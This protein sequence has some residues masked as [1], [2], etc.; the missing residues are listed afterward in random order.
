MIIKVRFPITQ[1]I[2]GELGISINGI[3]E[4]AKGGFGLPRIIKIG[5]DR[6]ESREAEGERRKSAM[7]P[8]ETRQYICDASP[9]ASEVVRRWESPIAAS[10]EIGPEKMKDTKRMR[11]G[12]STK[13]RL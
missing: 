6:G 5:A 3:R 1:K 12:G 10:G 9:S 2:L 8:G 13:A 11:T 7:P 4:K